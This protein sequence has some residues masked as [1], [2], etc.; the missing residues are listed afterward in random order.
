M[1]P[2]FKR[3]EREVLKNMKGNTEHCSELSYGVICLRAEQPGA[4]LPATHLLP[5]HDSGGL[6]RLSRQILDAFET[7]DID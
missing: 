2:N 6:C 7:L 1:L 5:G 3:K 4:V